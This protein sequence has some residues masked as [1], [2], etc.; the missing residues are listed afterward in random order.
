MFDDLCR[1]TPVYDDPEAHA[2]LEKVLSRL[3][4]TI[5]E[6]NKAK[7]DPKTR[8]LIE[9]TW[10]L[11][12][13]LEFK[14][15]VSFEPSIRAF[16][17]PMLMMNETLPRAIVFRLLGHVLLCGVL[18]VAYQTSDRVK[19]Q[20]MICVLY[21]SCLVLATANRFHSPFTVVA[22]IGLANGSVEDADNGRG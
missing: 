20:Y 1:N 12:D 7:D 19:G 17:I 18:H 5:R 10:L 11:Q 22:S 6:V 3:Q 14:E 2:E 16:V 9:I 15:Q 8:R 21:K 13:R 4:E